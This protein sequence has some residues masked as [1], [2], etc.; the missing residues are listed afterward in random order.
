MNH[1]EIIQKSWKFIEEKFKNAWPSH[2]IHHVK[3]VYEMACF[4]AE[5]EWANLF[6]VELWALFHDISDHKYGGTEQEWDEIIQKF[7]FSLWVQ[8]EIISQVQFIVKHISYSSE[9]WGKIE[10]SLELQVVQD[11]DRLDALWAVGIARCFCYTWEKWQEMYNPNISPKLNMT[12]EE[13][14]SHKATA[15]NHFYEKLLN[16]KDRINTQTAKK[17]AEK[18][19]QT[20]ETFLKDFLEEVQ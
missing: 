16:I 18:R 19:H 17:I 15:I 14:R 9:L 20:M 3:R 8:Q 13:Y 4:L 12:K 11:A 5:K 6:V 10:K 2:D 7:L 1:D